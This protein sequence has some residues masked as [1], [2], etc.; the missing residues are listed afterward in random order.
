MQ[1]VH[2]CVNPWAVVSP[3]RV[4]SRLCTKYALPWEGVDFR[5]MMDFFIFWS[6]ECCVSCMAV[7]PRCCASAIQATQLESHVFAC[8][9]RTAGQSTV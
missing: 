2:G 1:C 4:S 9:A 6:P 3:A 5:M 8:H 7:V